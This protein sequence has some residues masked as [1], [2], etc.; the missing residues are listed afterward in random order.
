M[1]TRRPALKL[2]CHLPPSHAPPDT[3]RNAKRVSRTRDPIRAG[4]AHERT[5]RTSEGGDGSGAESRERPT[6]SLNPILIL[7]MSLSDAR[8]S[9]KEQSTKASIPYQCFRLGFISR[10]IS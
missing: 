2:V 8:N 3:H 9:K 6:Q 5:K 4:G 1:Q 10:L 7:M